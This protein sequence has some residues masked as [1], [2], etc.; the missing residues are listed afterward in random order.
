MTQTASP[1]ATGSVL[2]AT[3]YMIGA[4][5]I[6]AVVNFTY[7]I[8]TNPWNPMLADDKMTSS[9]AVFWQYLIATIFAI[10]LI[11]RIGLNKLR[12]RHPVLHEVRALVSALGAQVFVFGFASGVPVWQMVGLLMTGPFFVI[13]GSVLFLG[14][15]LSPARIGASIVAFAGALIVVGVGSESFTWASLLPVLAAA[16]WSTTT[17]ISKYLSREESAESLTL[18]LLVLISLNHALIATALGALVLILPAGTLPQSLSTGLDLGFPV[19][20]ATWVILGLGLV[21]AVTQYLLWTAY[22]MADATYLQPFDDL[23]LPL[24]LLLGWLV[25]SQVPDIRFW[26]GAVLIVGASVF[27]AMRENRRKTTPSAVTA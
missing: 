16:L 4:Q 17:V 14:E 19:S 12:T 8:L 1:G 9:S 6:F 20:A 24:N 25:L 7:D 13:A 21:T 5:V 26:P 27:I 2:S 22:K 10:P 15:R 18:Y 23:K 3:L 11:F